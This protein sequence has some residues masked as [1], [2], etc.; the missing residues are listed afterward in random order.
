LNAPRPEPRTRGHES[1][2]HEL[3]IPTAQMQDALMGPEKGTH[4]LTVSTWP[5][6][7][8]ACKCNQ[9]SLTIRIYMQACWGWQERTARTFL[10]VDAA[11]P[12]GFLEKTTG[13]QSCPPLFM[14]IFSGG[15]VCRKGRGRSALDTE[16]AQAVRPT[17][18]FTKG[19]SL[20]FQKPS[21]SLHTYAC[22]SCHYARMGKFTTRLHSQ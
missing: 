9:A 22:S 18:S 14:F 16:F 3:A 1:Q 6:D 8:C 21:F 10:E 13:V 7:C 11:A 5:P 12:V 17:N 20:L 4:F 19:P 15:S 2:K